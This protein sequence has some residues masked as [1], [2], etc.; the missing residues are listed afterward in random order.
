MSRYAAMFAARAR[1][2]SAPSSCS[3]IRTSTASA[4]ILDAL[5]EGGADMLEVGIPFSD[6][7]ADGPV[8][9]AAAA[10][11]LAAGTRPADCFA[12]LAAFRARHPDDA[13]RHPH[14]C[15]SRRGARP[16][17]ISTRR[18]AA[19]GVDSVLVADVPLL[20]AAP[21]AAAARAHGVAPV[22]IAAANT[23]PRTAARD[24]GAGRRLHLLRRP[25]RGDGRRRGGRASTM[26]TMLAALREAG[27]P[28]PVFG[29][30]ISRPD[31][32]RAALAAGAAGVIS[33]LGDRRAD[34]RRR[35]TVARLRP[36]DEGGDALLRRGNRLN[37][38]PCPPT[39]STPRPAGPR[40]RPAPGKRVTA[41]AILARKGKEPIVALTAYTMRMA[42]LLDPHCDLLL[43]GDSLGQVIYGLPSTI[44]VSLEMM[45]AH[46]AAVVRGSWHALVAVDMPFGSYEESPE[47]AFRNAA[48]VLKETG[49]AAVKLEGGEAMAE[50]V[51][52]LVEARHSGDRPC[53]ADP[54]GGERARRLS[55]AGPRRC[56]GRGR[57]SPTPRRSPRR[58]ASRW[59]IEGVMEEIAVEATEGGRLPD[60]RHR[61]LGPV[62]RPDP[63]HRGHDGHVRADAAL[64]EALRRSRRARSARRPPPMPRTSRAAPSRPKSRSTGPR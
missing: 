8:I 4:A 28:P 27:A 63:G 23:P 9:Q 41:P 56:R 35:A 34:R 14:L 19:A 46:G 5:V 16:R 3:A 43:V 48:R 42:Q 18:A 57:C 37:G 52:F 64:R 40:R 25:R 20:E 1:A 44:P 45:C 26:A 51:A 12:L 29:F 36:G 62:R 7:V 10:R 39:R 59:C 31:H 33:R 22:L 15:Q 11:A 58:A 61:R 50:T 38:S 24:R 13:G 49:A 54:A 47:Q 21:F 2:R 30:G 60:D 53:R 32:V 6:P 17:T 55:R